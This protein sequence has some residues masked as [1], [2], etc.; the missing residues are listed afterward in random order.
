M[1]F[2]EI[3]PLD[4]FNLLTAFIASASIRGQ[5]ILGV[6]VLI[7]AV[8]LYSERRSRIEV[9]E[10]REQ[11]KQTAAF[12]ASAKDTFGH[13]IAI[14]ELVEKHGTISDFQKDLILQVAGEFTT[15]VQNTLTQ[16]VMIAL[17]AKTQAEKAADVAK[18]VETGVGL[19]P[20]SLSSPG[21][22]PNE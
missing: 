1:I 20:K 22:L 11:R 7:L 13:V 2:A 14:L 4:V 8:T 15:T 6:L 12:L 19:K 18:K 21:N 9:R 16:T 3:E 5:I 10:C 17:D